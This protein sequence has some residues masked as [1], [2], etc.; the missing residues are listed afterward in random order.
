M[1][2]SLT[3]HLPKQ[4]KLPHID[5]K[6]PSRMPPTVILLQM[7]N[8]VQE[9]QQLHAQFVVT[10]LLHHPLNP[11][12][13]LESYVASSQLN[14]AL[15]VFD[16]IPSPD[17]F[18]YNTMIRGLTMRKRPHESVLLYNKL[19][20]NGV[21]PDNYTYTFVL[22]S[23]SHLKALS[24]G[25]QVHCQIIKAGISPNTHV[26]SSL[27]RMY[28]NCGYMVYAKK[29]HAE[30][31][32]EN[33]DATNSILSGYLCQGLVEEARS[34]FDKMPAKDV[35]S[36]SCMITGYT[37]NGLY[38]EA[39]SLF[40]DMTISR[41]LP[42]ESALV[43]LLSAC[44]NSG[45][46]DQGRW[47]HAYIGRIRAEVSVTLGTALIN[48][49]ARCGDIESGFEVFQKM[50]RIDIGT[51][52]AIMAGFAMDGQARKCFELFDLMS[53][54]ELEPNSGDR[55]KQAGLM[56]ANAGDITETAKISKLIKDKEL[57]MTCGS[58][59]IEVEGEIHQFV[60]ADIHHDKV[61]DIYRMLEGIT[62]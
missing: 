11:A 14:Y 35:A 60:V 58:S 44:A 9:I 30:F 18:A 4:S 31:S 3:L 32:E 7:C 53:L 49:Y 34:I 52:G 62:S 47:I 42:N 54:I 5:P 59:L 21:K 2:S 15:S 6:T 40:Q 43:S 41:V 12:R 48:M 27:I 22:K 50:N 56:F 61:K 16:T 25:Q 51:W 17:Q 8:T 46:L 55:Y 37:N 33:I 23:C 28:S 19:L 39:L 24:E 20:L 36:W 26:H 45:A 29:V 57:G 38:I 10:G 13:L 1:A